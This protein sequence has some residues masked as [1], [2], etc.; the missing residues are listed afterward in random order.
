METT[1]QQRDADDR[2]TEV[3]AEVGINHNGSLDLALRLIDV[4]ELAGADYVKFQKRTPELCVPDDQKDRP[5]ETPWGTMPYL[6]YKKRIEFGEEEFDVIDDYCARLGI[7]WFLSVWDEPSVM[8]AAQYDS[9]PY[10][11]I[12]SACITDAHLVRKVATT[13]RHVIFSTG[14]STLDE[15][16]VAESIVRQVAGEGRYTILHCHSAYPAPHDELNL[17]MIPE[18]RERYLARVGYSGHE[19][20]LE[21][22]VWAVVMGAEM[23]ERHV[24]LSHDMWGSDHEASVEPLPLVQLVKR[25]RSAERAMGDG[26]DRVWESEKPARTRLRGGA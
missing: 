4:A 9:A 13:G 25:I 1:S 21:P 3:V 23:I 14:M 6:E 17:R 2:R 8:F 22:S 26:E 5:R 15:V 24:T 10:I 12:P 19:Y 16:D 7:P 20:G 18:L 11:K